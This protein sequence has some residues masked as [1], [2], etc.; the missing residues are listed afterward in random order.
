[1]KLIAVYGQ[2]ERQVLHAEQSSSS[3]MATC[4]EMVTSPLHSSA[5]A[6]EAAAP[7]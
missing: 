5:N 4:G 1:M 7:A 6:I 3:T 2:T